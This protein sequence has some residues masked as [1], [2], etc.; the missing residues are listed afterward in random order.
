MKFT[1]PSGTYATMLLREV[2]KHS[3]HSQYQTQLTASAA[4]AFAANSVVNSNIELSS[5]SACEHPLESSTMESP[6]K[7][8]RTDL[9][10]A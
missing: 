7:K 1:L 2:T 6:R 9:I 3:T 5:D 4:A 10:S 8:S